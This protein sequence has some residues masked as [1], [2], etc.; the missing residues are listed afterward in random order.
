MIEQGLEVI[1]LDRIKTL[2]SMLTQMNELHLLSKEF[3]FS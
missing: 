2:P 1:A 3:V